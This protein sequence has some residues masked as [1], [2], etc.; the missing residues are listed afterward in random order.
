MIGHVMVCSAQA[1]LRRARGFVKRIY[2]HET[3]RFCDARREKDAT[4]CFPQCDVAFRLKIG[5]VALHLGDTSRLRRRSGGVCSIR[6]VER[7]MQ[8]KLQLQAKQ[9]SQRFRG[10]R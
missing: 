9:A 10:Y 5:H 7:E 2:W 1:L 3:T 4:V 8:A 6:T